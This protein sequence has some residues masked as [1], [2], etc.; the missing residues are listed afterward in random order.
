MRRTVAIALALCALISAAIAHPVNIYSAT[1]TIED[2]TAT[3]DL[4]INTHALDHE[5]MLFA[6]E[7]SDD[8]ILEALA[9]SV[10]I[11]DV[12]DDLLRP[13][14]VEVRGDHAIAVYT[15]A[16]PGVCSIAQQPIGALAIGRRVIAVTLVR[17]GTDT[18]ARTVEL[19]SGANPE[20]ISLTARPIP[21]PERFTRPRIAVRSATE[22]VVDFPRRILPRTAQ[23]NPEIYAD[24]VH[25]NLPGAEIARINPTLLGPDDTPITDPD[26]HNPAMIRARAI[27]ILDHPIESLTWTGFTASLRACDVLDASGDR[28]A[29]LNPSSNTCAIAPKGDD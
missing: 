17:P 22:L 14:S 27:V 25:E 5:R 4:A 11:R 26:A 24:W 7:P 21:D 3:L 1:L 9:R 2:D 12:L 15:L 23:Q 20:I 10:R 16:D 19:S 13:D 28:L 18:P 29:T 6:D 8:D